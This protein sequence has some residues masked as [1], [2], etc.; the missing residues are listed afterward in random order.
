MFKEIILLVGVRGA[1]KDYTATSLLNKK[2]TARII[3]FSDGVRD[4]T[5]K[6]LGWEPESHEKYEEFK[7]SEIILHTGG[8]VH[9]ITGRNF[10]INIGD[11]VMKHYDHEVWAKVWER[12]ASNIL[13]F[14]SGNPNTIIAN[15]LRH[16]NEYLTARATAFEF[17][18][19]LTVIFCDYR[20]DR[21][22]ISDDSTEALAVSILNTGLFKD[23]D[24]ITKYMEDLY[25]KWD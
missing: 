19:K 25:G 18:A 4:Y 23:G 3:G 17:G 15:D 7:K 5:W 16:I 21:Y 20:S 9:K 24:D 12:K 1:G 6:A 11:K 10:L 2:P 8:V 22:E 13:K 14:S